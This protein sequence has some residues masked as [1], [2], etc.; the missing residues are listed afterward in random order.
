[1]NIF[2]GRRIFFNTRRWTKF[3]KRMIP[4]VTYRRQNLTEEVANFRQQQSFSYYI[5][6][7]RGALQNEAWNLIQTITCVKDQIFGSDRNK[8]QLPYVYEE[9]N[10]RINL[11]ITATFRFGFFYTVACLKIQI[12]NYTKLWFFP[13]LC[14]TWNLVCCIK[15]RR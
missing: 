3:M 4:N 10:N 7:L 1:M 12:L 14:R 5:H 11:G 6:P 15:G 9:I 8:P 13:L 2:Y